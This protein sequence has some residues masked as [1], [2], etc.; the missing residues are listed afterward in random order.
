MVEVGDWGW[1]VRGGDGEFVVVCSWWCARGGVSMRCV[2]GGEFGMWGGLGRG[3][4][5]G[6]D[7][8]GDLVLVCSC[9]GG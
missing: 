9:R 3:G 7:L 6:G 4:V 1:V 2:R 8:C 5:S